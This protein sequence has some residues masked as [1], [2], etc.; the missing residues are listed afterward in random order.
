M[1]MILSVVG[2]FGALLWDLRWE[3]KCPHHQLQAAGW[4]EPRHLLFWKVDCKSGRQG[5]CSGRKARE[6]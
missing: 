2:G 5:I 1:G 6:G 3:E 4:S